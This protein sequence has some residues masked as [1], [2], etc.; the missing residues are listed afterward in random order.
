MNWLDWLILAFLALSIWN[1]F[2]EGAVRV[3]IGFIALIVGFLAASWFYGI[4]ADHMLPWVKSR[5]L[6]NLFGFQI[7]FFGVIIAGALIAS[8]IAQVFKLVGLTWVDR[9]L[10]AGAGVVRG[11]LVVVVCM[12]VLLAFAPKR[13]TG[14]VDQSRFAPYILRGSN[15]IKDVT[16]YEIK[17]GFE[18]GYEEIR[19]LF[20]SLK[21]ATRLPISI[22]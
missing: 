9:L 16:P 22:D 3:G 18:E 17:H 7:I 1:G 5:A 2:R 13:L 6:A 4:P 14:A 21:G 10:G 19:Y 20:R 11:A 15:V 8:L 12:M